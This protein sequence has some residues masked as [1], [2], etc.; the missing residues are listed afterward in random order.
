MIR[1]VRAYTFLALMSILCFGCL[2]SGDDKNAKNDPS[3]GAG[4]EAGQGGAGGEAGSGGGTGGGAGEG[5]AAGTGGNAGNAGS[6]GSTP[7]SG[8]NCGSLNFVNMNEVASIDGDRYVLEGNTAGRNNFQEVANRRPKAPI[9]RFDSNYRLRA[10]GNSAPK[11]PLMTQ[12]SMHGVR[13]EDSESELDC[14]DD[15]NY[16]AGLVQSRVKVE[17]DAGDYVFL[18]VDAYDNLDLKTL[19][20]RRVHS[21]QPNHQRL[22]VLMSIS[23]P[24]HQN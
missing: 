17:G 14:N 22:I 4:G 9:W 11:R 20:F 19:R 7:T 21:S 3:G 12:S 2:H 10:R 24:N 23:T 18:I 15:I 8:P 1:S 13:A 6:G 5:G 16:E